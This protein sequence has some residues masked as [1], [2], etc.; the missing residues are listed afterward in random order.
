MRKILLTLGLLLPTLLIQAQKQKTSF[1]T[2]RLDALEQTQSQGT[3][4][5]QVTG[6]LVCNTQYVAGTTMDL[7]FTL[8]L[9]NTDFEYCDLFSITFPAGITPNSSPTDPLVSPAIDPIAT[10]TQLNPIVGQTVSWGADDDLNQFGGIGTGT[11]Y[12]FTINVTISAGVTGNQIAS[13]IAD[14][15]SYGATPGDLNGI[16]TIYAAGSSLPDIKSFYVGTFNNGFLDRTCSLGSDTVLVAITNLGNTTESNILVNY[17]VNGT[18]IG[19]S[20]AF[21]PQTG[22]TDIAPG[23][24]A[25]AV[26]LPSFDFSAAGIYDIQAWVDQAGDVD[27]SNDSIQ[28]SF[29]NTT[30]TALTSTN[31]TNGIESQFD[32]FSLLSAWN[33]PGTGFGI[34]TV[35]IHTGLQALFYTVN[36][37]IGAPVGNYETYLVM[38]CTDVVE[39]DIYKVSYWRKSN[40]SGTISINGN[41]GVFV[42]TNGDIAS[43]T[44]TLKTYSA[45]TPNP[46]AAAWQKDSVNYS[47]AADGTVYFSIGAK[48]SVTSTSG[49]NVRID[50]ILIEKVCSREF[51]TVS[52]SGCQS[53]TWNGQ[54]YSVSG[55]YTDTL[56]NTL[57]CDSVVT[58]NLTINSLPNISALAGTAFVCANGSTNLTA[59]GAATYTWSNNAGTGAT[60]TVSLAVNTIYTVTGTDA[61]GCSNTATV[62]VS[63]NE[64]P[65]GSAT[66]IDAGCGQTNGSATVSAT[67]GLAP[68]TYTWSNSSTTST[69]TGLAAGQYTATITD[70][71]QCSVTVSNINVN[72]SNAPSVNISSQDVTCNGGSNGSASASLTGG[73]APFTYNWSNNT[74]NNTVTNISAGDYTLTVTDA[75]SCVSLITVTINEPAA[76]NLATSATNVLCKGDNTGSASVTATGGTAGYTYNWNTSPAQSTATASGVAAGTYTLTVTDANLCTASTQVTISEPQEVLSASTNGQNVFCF[77]NNSGLANANVNG[78]TTPYTYLWSNGNTT[79]SILNLTANTYTVVITDANGCTVNSE[80]TITQPQSALSVSA[81]VNG[82]AVNST[83]TGGTAPYT[84]LWSNGASTQNISGVAAGTYTVTV[85]D[86]NGCTNVASA[87]VSTSSLEEINDNVNVSLYPNPA[88]SEFKIVISEENVNNTSFVVM[89][90]DGRILMASTNI[91]SSEMTINTNS[92]SSGV[93]FVQFYSNQ[94]IAV[95]KLI[96]RK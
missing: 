66:T 53:Y 6:S 1:N 77:G 90:E 84:Y 10:P 63:V 5:K 93:Y 95:K 62:S 59:T 94:G 60:V 75:N 45:I 32:Y 71:N 8:L 82:S 48:G 73:S 38:P 30:P 23:D 55:S 40:T 85:T 35:T 61:N 58:L 33:G 76:I 25:I 92:F 91:T 12:S 67:G 31:Y 89:T 70:A 51:N 50:D 16:S 17:S 41:T 15:D 68:Y 22:S 56:T 28:G 74:S 46:Q 52:A 2:R 34:S 47:A 39:G 72:N 78:G 43:I 26:F 14:G 64:N 7:S 20:A 37:G 24:T 87:T 11:P 19:Q 81:V 96:V 57:G 54:T 4:T 18:T 9:T 27:L 79:Q 36:T 13:F 49:I 88:S 65:T 44:D 69:A 21:H 29:T 3:I 86:A 42:G 83:A 80:A